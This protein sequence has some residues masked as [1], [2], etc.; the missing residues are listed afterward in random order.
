L[1]QNQLEPFFTGL[2]AGFREG[3]N[4]EIDFDGRWKPDRDQL[5]RLPVTAEATAIIDELAHAPL[6]LN[7]INAADFD[8]EDIRALVVKRGVGAN[9]RILLQAFS[10]QQRLSRKF[11]LT[12]R[13]N[14][15]NRL[16]ESTFSID[17]QIHIII[18]NGRIK[19]KTFN[20]AKR[21]LDLTAVYEE[22]TDRDIEELCNLGRVSAN[23]ADIINISNPTIRKLITA[24]KN[25]GV[26]QDYTANAIRNKAHS[27]NLEIT[28][29][30][31]GVVLPTDRAELKKLLTFLDHGVYMSPVS[32]ERY[33]ANSRRAL[34]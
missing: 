34:P 27:V 29:R 6:A 18:E 5:L 4:E 23:A 7:P 16:T 24:V 33:I 1:V 17:S 25:S 26:F 9:T 28:V 2:E 11:A 12:Q 19:F 32:S 10:N 3:I 8:D 14:V 15:F 30:N 21:I 13:G 20:M 22:A 31:H